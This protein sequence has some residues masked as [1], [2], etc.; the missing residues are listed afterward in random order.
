M[1]VVDSSAWLEYF[2]GGPNAASFA[3]AIEDIDSLIVPSLTIFEVFKRV[4]QQRD[5]T[6]ALRATAAMHQGTVVDLDSTL[7]INAARLSQ[8]FKLPLADSIILATARAQSAT[9]WTQDAD[10]EGMDAVEYRRK[11]K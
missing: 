7:A 10:F 11:P 1:N 5:E 6:A 8:D 2:A 4:L 3:P 9:L